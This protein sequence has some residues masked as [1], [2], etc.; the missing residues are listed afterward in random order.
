MKIDISITPE[1][2]IFGDKK[3][4]T[5]WFVFF[6][7]LVVIAIALGGYSIYAT[8]IQS[9]NFEDWSLGLLVVAAVGVTIF[10]NKLQAYKS[11]FPPQ[12][13]KLSLLRT[14]YAPI[15]TY[16]ACVDTLQR[17]YIR[18]EYEA[19]IEYAE[20]EE[21]KKE[22]AEPMDG[23]IYGPTENPDKEFK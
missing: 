11:L 20:L 19:C 18:A 21:T 13:E 12:R 2:D 16:C 23:M 5:I 17:R 7:M 3:R 10:G 22:Q 6:L 15:E 1:N 4:H 8:N 14:Q 9:A